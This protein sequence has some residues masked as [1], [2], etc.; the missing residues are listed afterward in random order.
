MPRAKQRLSREDW[1]RAALDAI[2]QAGL[3]AVAVEPLAARLGVTK[4]SFYAH[5]RNRD[6]LIDAALTRWRESHAA[7]LSDLD[8]IDDPKERLERVFLAAV[9]FS[10]S[11]SPSVHVRLLGEL[12]DPRAR[13]AVAAVTQA[14]VKRLAASYRE[15][16]LDRR[17]A[18]V[19][20]RLAYATYVGL[21]QIAQETPDRV[22]TKAQI[23]AVMAEL[24]A[25]LLAGP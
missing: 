25:T 6:A 22:M 20:A 23:T 24:R 12:Q 8:G 17:R 11:S 19:R 15:L 10:Q 16:G 14:R 7:S 13:E 5:F 3:A 1:I 9:T 4:G 21:L 2:A 18:D